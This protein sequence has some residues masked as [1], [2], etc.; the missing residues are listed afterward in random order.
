MAE[1]MLV[2]PRKRR[3]TT[4][5][6]RKTTARRKTNPRRKVAAAPKRNPIRR[7]RAAPVARRKARRSRRRN[8]SARSILNTTLIPALTAGA[9]AIGFNA[10]WN[11]VPLPEQL[12][13][14]MVQHVAKA[15]GAIGLGMVA[16]NVVGRKR[17]T[18]LVAGALTVIAY[19][20]LKDAVSQVAPTVN[21]GYYSA[22]QPAGVLAYEGASLGEYVGGPMGEY[23]G[24]GGGYLAPTLAEPFA[25]PAGAGRGV[26][27]DNAMAGYY[28]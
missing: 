12:K 19:N 28:S 5:K 13:T 24:G 20:A 26:E 3:K 17:A 6:R 27:R 14:G 1:L 25:S 2:N 15:A 10:L 22:G 9:G 7:R 23:V 16:G 18:E 11:F 8:P 4:A 21:L